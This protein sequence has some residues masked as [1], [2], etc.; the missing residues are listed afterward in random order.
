MG[1]WQNESNQNYIGNL[2][3]ESVVMGH[4]PSLIT[5]KVF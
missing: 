3:L 1:S 2:F 5:K 4:R